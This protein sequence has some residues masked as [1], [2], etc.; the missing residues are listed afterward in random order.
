LP[1]D[2]AAHAAQHATLARSTA[3]KVAAR[4]VEGAA[5][6]DERR[7]TRRM[8]SRL[9][10]FARAFWGEEAL[11]AFGFNLARHAALASPPTPPPPARPLSPYQSSPRH[12]FRP[13]PRSSEIHLGLK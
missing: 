10:G 9:K 12:P 6:R 3:G 2:T 5:L 7:R 8:L 13:F 11:N 4:Q 1:T